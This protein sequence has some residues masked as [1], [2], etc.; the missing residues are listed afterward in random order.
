MP[1]VCPI[2]AQ[3][4]PQ[5]KKQEPGSFKPYKKDAGGGGV[6]AIIQGVIDVAKAPATATA[7]GHV[8]AAGFMDERWRP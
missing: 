1:N 4:F 6:L 3:Y 7:P 2:F 5:G 8:V